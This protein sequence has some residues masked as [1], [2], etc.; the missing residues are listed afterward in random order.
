MKF[1]VLVIMI[2]YYP[3][4][5]I[6]DLGDGLFSYDLVYRPPYEAALNIVYR[7]K[8][9]GKLYEVTINPYDAIKT[10]PVKEVEIPELKFEHKEGK[11]TR[12]HNRKGKSP[13]HMRYNN[14]KRWIVNKG[15]KNNEVYEETSKLETL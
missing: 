11:K 12:K 4:Q 2:T 8:K 6:K 14:E 7:A 13:A 15:K 9:E 1:L 3:H 5:G 10:F